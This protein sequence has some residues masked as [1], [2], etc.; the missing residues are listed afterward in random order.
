MNE[1]SKDLSSKDLRE[2]LT[3]MLRAVFGIENSA[4]KEFNDAIDE[5]GNACRKEELIY[6]EEK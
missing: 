2:K 3:N 6:K 4:F 5:Y 1:K